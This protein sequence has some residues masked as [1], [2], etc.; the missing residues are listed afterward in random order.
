[1]S[2]CRECGKWNGSSAILPGNSTDHLCKCATTSEPDPTTKMVGPIN[3]DT[4]TKIYNENFNLCY[5]VTLR[6][7][8]EGAHS[9]ST[10]SSKDLC[11]LAA[12][13][14]TEAMRHMK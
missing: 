3:N 14:A 11:D 4:V 2:N 5:M 6:A 12:H 7:V 9:R 13:F 8:I 1:M 10:A